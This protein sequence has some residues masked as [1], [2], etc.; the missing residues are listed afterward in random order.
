MLH[1]LG[2]ALPVDLVLQEQLQ[3]GW[4]GLLVELFGVLRY[5]RPIKYLDCGFRLAG[6]TGEP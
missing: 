6:A 5:Y 1:F 4:R 3:V 2:I